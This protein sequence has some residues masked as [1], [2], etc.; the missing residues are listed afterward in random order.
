MCINSVLLSNNCIILTLMEVIK[1]NTYNYYDK[2]LKITIEI[3]VT[4]K[5]QRYTGSPMI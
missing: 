2:L 3:F 1:A 4:E 5:F